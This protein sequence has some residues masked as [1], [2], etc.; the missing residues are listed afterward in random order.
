MWPRNR[1]SGDE[2]AEEAL[3]NLGVPL[4]IGDDPF[5]EQS[6]E[7][8]RVQADSG[9]L[10]A[11][12]EALGFENG[13]PADREILTEVHIV[14]GEHIAPITG[15]N[16]AEPLWKQWRDELSV[17]GGTSPLI[18][19]VDS[20]RTRIDITAMHPGGMAQFISGKPVLLSNLI[21]EEFALR[22]ARLAASNVVTKSTELRSMRGIES[23]YLAIGVANWRFGEVDYCGPVLLRPLSLRRYGKD[24]ELRLSSVPFL[25]P[26][27]AHALET[28]LHVSLDAE[29]FV[30]LA[31]V[32]GMFDPQP[33]IER[34]RG[35]T[36]HYDQFSVEPNLYVSTFAD[37]SAA[38]VADVR[39]LQHPVLDALA[40]NISARQALAAGAHDVASVDQDARPPATDNLLLDADSEQEN[41]VAEIV[42]GNSLIVRTL[43][44]TGGTQS[45]VNSLGALASAHK[46]VL[47][48]GARRSSLDSIGQ[49]LSQVGVEGL[50]VAPRTLRRDL[51]AAI[52]RNEKAV[53][54]NVTEVDDALLR[55]RKVLLDYRGSLSRKDPVLGVSA[56]D[57]LEELSALALLPTPPST[58]ARLPRQAIEGLANMRAEAA[59]SL[60][61]AAALGEFKYGPNDSPWYGANFPTAEETNAAH[62]LAK[63]LHS[64]ELPKLLERADELVGR[65]RMRPY[66]S[67]DELGVYIRLL[68]DIRETLDKFLPS[69]YDRPLN[70]LIAAYGSRADNKMAG[71]DRRRLK[72]LAYEYV[73]PGASVSDMGAALE[74]IQEQRVLWQRY[75]V[76]G[77]VPEVPVGVADL[78]AAYQRVTGD[79]EILDT[80]LSL[81]GTDQAMHKLDLAILRNK[82]QGLAAD[83]EVLQNLQ[84][85]TQL[86][87]HLR[88]LDLDI[89]LADLSA[90][91]IPEGQVANELELA[92]WQSV[93]EGM[94][95]EDKALLSAN[96]AILD[97]LEADFRLVDEAHSSANGSLLAARLAELWKIGLVDLP[98]E[99]ERLRASLR[100]PHI[101]PEKFVAVAPR[102]NKAIAPVWLCSPYEAHLI[103]E[104]VTF[105]AVFLIDAGATTIA[106]NAGAIR[107]GNQV[108][109]FGDPVTQTP[110]SFETGM[111]EFETPVAHNENADAWHARSALAVFTPI[112]PSR[113]LTRSYR[114]GGEDLADVINRRFYGGKIKSLPWAGT[115]LGHSSLRFHYIADGTGMPDS[116]TGAVESVDAEVA[117]VVELVLEHAKERPNESLMVIT[118]SPKHA[119]RVEQSVLSAFARRP[120]VAEFILEDRA[121]PFTVMT[122][123]QA[124]A[125]SRDRVIFSVGF[126]RTPH[127]RLLADFGA[128]AKPGGQRLLAVGMTRARRSMEI[129]SCFRPG[130]IDE[131]R[132]SDGMKALA[133]VLSETDREISPTISTESSEP[134]LVDLAKR[135]ERRGMRVSLN[136]AGEIALAASYQ[137]RAVAVE[138]DAALERGSL[139]ESLR[140][141]PDVLRRLGWHYLRIHAFELF[142][143]PEAIADRIGSLIGVPEPTPLEA[144][145]PIVLPR[146]ERL[147]HEVPAVELTAEIDIDQEVFVQMYDAET[148]EIDVTEVI[149]VTV[150]EDRP[151]PTFATEE[152]EAMDAPRRVQANPSGVEIDESFTD[153]ASDTSAEDYADRTQSNDEKLRQDKPP[154]WG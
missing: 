97:R 118:A 142:A 64:T 70:E 123:E 147:E 143:D 5:P 14:E 112:L 129:V 39:D 52:L 135:L 74:R 20:A 116:A 154:H 149:T 29:A 111:G 67:L 106:E 130:D 6:A 41:I 49:R 119:V 139:R 32:N 3:P 17:V 80:A 150:E 69:V 60:I 59:G 131:S 7:S 124:V 30:G 90:R 133:E 110:S 31:T 137:G 72:K 78:Q 140:L 58:T 151:A 148:A 13:A 9:S 65:T 75:V 98:D 113:T 42:A 103:P 25:N 86:L 27:L 108:V 37:L 33:V 46:R 115:F 1:K 94:L 47:V 84:E 114:A 40:G 35:L 28:Q 8:T 92:W 34:L 95:T 48:V 132:L 11:A 100:D 117:R 26:A 57:A 81:N 134:M 109:V 91:H 93:L 2:P 10:D 71:G 16:V 62:E 107:R 104:G 121:E 51:I 4:E 89:L 61:K 152:S 68:I 146:T 66:E 136:H 79:L 23:V 153:S 38:M 45:I 127:G 12:V 138:T 128:L 101:S 120:D 44:G 21:R 83:S 22:N 56:L 53:R 125:Q 96:T 85:R 126:G 122:L 24:F 102:L 87:A 18:Q 54:P 76:A 19:F 73:R 88:E 77:A 99:A 145:G 144:T 43:P 82:I 141:R 15:I 36:Q 63:R 50:T 55:L 105:D